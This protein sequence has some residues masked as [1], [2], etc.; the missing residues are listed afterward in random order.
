[1]I[2]GRPSAQHWTLE[3][4]GFCRGVYRVGFDELKALRSKSLCKWHCVF[5]ETSY[6]NS[7][8]IG[9]LASL[10]QRAGE[11]RQIRVTCGRNLKQGESNKLLCQVSKR[12]VWSER[13]GAAAGRQKLSRRLTFPC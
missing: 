6:S 5:T 3:S 9:R 12:S 7:R 1:M 4:V 10:Q 8:C 13:E 2:E 11:R